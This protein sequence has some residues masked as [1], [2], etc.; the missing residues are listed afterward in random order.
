MYRH[1]TLRTTLAAG[2]LAAGLAACSDD[3]ATTPLVFDDDAPSALSRPASLG[4]LQDRAAAAPLRLEIEVRPGGPPWIAREVEIENDDDDEEKIESRIASADALAGSITLVLGDLTVD[5]SAASRFR[6]EGTGDVSMAGFFERVD[7]ALA[8]GRT[9]GVELR[10][11]LP[12]EP[13]DP[14]DP[15]F[16]PRDVRLDDDADVGELEVLVDDR[17]VAA[18]SDSSGRITVFGVEIVVDRSLGSEV[19]ERTERG[20]GAVEVEG[21]VEAVDPAGGSVA[22]RGGLTFRIVP[23]TR[24][25]ADDDEPSSLAQVADALAAG[26]WVEVEGELVR[27]TDGSWIAVEVEFEIEDDADDDVFGSSEFEGQV[28]AAD[29]VA[30]SF[31]LQNGQTLTLDDGTRIEDDGD[32]FSI[33]QVAAALGAS[34]YVEAE[35]HVLPDATAPGGMRVVSVKFETDDDDADDDG[36]SEFEGVAAAVDAGAGTFTLANGATYGVDDATRYEA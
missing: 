32:V 7:A 30:R 4:Q 16:L 29:P 36:T 34:L 27:D 26:Y 28:T 17:H 31:T 24:F 14:D 6:A 22:I 5:V 10:R 9:P 3:T 23:G 20:D 18:D 2:L 33:E 21:L 12:A 1:P 35:G 25:D 8:A 11:R 13:Q 19:G 15:S